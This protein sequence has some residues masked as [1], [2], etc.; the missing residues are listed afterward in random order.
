MDNLGYLDYG[1]LSN[2]DLVLDGSEDRKLIG[3]GVGYANTQRGGRRSTSAV[4]TA[5][6]AA[7]APCLFE[8]LRVNKAPRYTRL[9]L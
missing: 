4:V 5:A 3:G 6:K 8:K 7:R 2:F 9:L 1:L